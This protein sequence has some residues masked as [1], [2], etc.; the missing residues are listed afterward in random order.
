MFMLEFVLETLGALLGGIFAAFL[1]SWLAWSAFKLVRHPEWGP[2]L[3]FILGLF[4]LRHR[5]GSS[6]VQ[7]ILLFS[8]IITL[9][10]WW[11]GSLWRARRTKRLESDRLAPVSPWRDDKMSSVEGGARFRSG[12]D[13]I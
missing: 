3:V 5:L 8:A 7:V 2:L 10:C 4:F 1:A 12:P 11:E 6:F 13:V 9:I